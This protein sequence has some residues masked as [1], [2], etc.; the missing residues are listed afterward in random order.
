VLSTEQSTALFRIAQEALTNVA[1]HAAATA[2]RV[3]L[4]REGEQVVL[5]VEDDGRG[6]GAETSSPSGSLG[7]VGMRE[8]AALLGG[9]VQITGSPGGGTTVEARVPFGA[10]G[11][12]AEAA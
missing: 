1:R 9:T 5:R 4:F 11:G 10:P 3:R 6:I 12:E 7:V 2:A 8:R